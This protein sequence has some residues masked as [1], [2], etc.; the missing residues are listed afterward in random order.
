MSRIKTIDYEDAEGR[1]KEIY[2]D[3]IKK[4]KKLADVY[5]IQSLRPKSII[6]HM[7]LYI[8]IM[9][10]RSTLSR[11]EREMMAVV[12][13]I[14]NNCSYCQAHHGEALN[15]YWKDEEKVKRLVK[16]IYEADLTL[17]ERKLCEF[18]Q[19]LTANPGLHDETDFTFLLRDAGIDDAGILDAVMVVS[20]FNFINRMVLALG[21]ELE[22]DEGKG[23]AY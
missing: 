17:R 1:L 6:R 3:I 15:N 14:T 2:D 5:K 18:A 7:D 10:S 9:F 4:R 8:E 20:Y 21:V 23:Y 12:V 19:H 22:E 11:A 13:S 16:G